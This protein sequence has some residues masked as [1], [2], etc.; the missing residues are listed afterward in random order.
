MINRDYLMSVF[1]DSEW[2]E[3]DGTPVLE[4]RSWDAR[5]GRIQAEWTVVSP[6]GQ[7][8]T[9]THNE[10]I[11]TLQ[12]LELRFAE[13]RLGVVDAFGGFDGSPLAR[14]SR[15]LIVLAEKA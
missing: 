1:R 5:A 13:A 2:H 14:D 11:Y 15:R 7:R 3:V 12:E 10:R 4:R 9:H 8:R 6:D